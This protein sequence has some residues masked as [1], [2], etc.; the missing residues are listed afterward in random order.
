MRVVFFGTYDTATHPRVLVLAQGLRGRG[1]TVL[2]CNA[3]LGVGTAA[4]VA[5]VRRPWRAV[6][7]VARIARRWWS[8]A[9]AAR[10]VRPRR[11]GTPLDAIVVGYLGLF[12]VHLA[13]LLFGRTPV[14]LD[15]MAGAADIAA[16]RRLG[17]RL[18]H[19]L[20]G[21]LDRAALARAD[22]VVV[23][24]DEQRDTLPRHVRERAVVCPVGAPDA[25]FDAGAG[26][27]PAPPGPLRVVFFGLYT[28]LQGAPAIGAAARLLA[29]R[30]VRFTMI[31]HGQDEDA[32]RRAAGG[33][34]VRWVPW[35]D[36]GELPALV[37]GHDVCLG[38]F[39]DGAKARRV[40]PNK[41]FQ[42]AAAGCAIVTA[43]TA[44]QRRA[45]DDAALFVPSGDPAALAAAL[46]RLATDR[47]ELDRLRG[48]ARGLAERDF[49]A[50]RAALPLW[51]RLAQS[52]RGA[53]AAAPA[54][55]PEAPGPDRSARSLIELDRAAR[56]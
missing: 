14:V 20:L 46:D 12:D 48:A 29:D 18:R 11:G 47:A 7:L 43:D 56:R 51:R 37:A 32:T 35:A 13:R 27:P 45:L 30:P 23:D 10:A 15:H 33:A 26:T 1:A 2:E 4:R 34:P 8:L 16:D 41:V 25:W 21:A 54:G 19:W 31:G 49:T 3:P 36:A 42:G 39:G 22:V 9:R 24:T 52:G 50:A 40:V 38:I 6:P 53:D 28:P 17:G 5:A 55:R 44:P